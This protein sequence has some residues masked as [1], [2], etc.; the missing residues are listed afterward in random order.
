MKI[1]HSQNGPSFVYQH[2]TSVSPIRED[3]EW[4]EKEVD[5]NF[6]WFKWKELENIR[7]QCWSFRINFIGDDFVKVI[8]TDKTSVEESRSHAIE[9]LEF[10]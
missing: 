6:L 2:V 1:G 3:H 4:E 5:E 8:N 7:V 9:A 10:V